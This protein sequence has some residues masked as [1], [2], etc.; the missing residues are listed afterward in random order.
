MRRPV[1]LLALLL[2][3]AALAEPKSCRFAQE[4]YNTLACTETDLEITV[5]LEAG[6]VSTPTGDL[7][8]VGTYD[9]PV[10]KTAVLEGFAGY[11][12]LTMGQLTWILS[13]HIAAGPAVATYYGECG[14][15]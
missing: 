9:G 8:I 3:A 7:E 1:F 10:A 5:D 13:V 4:C 12:L 6:Q 11:Q 14:A 2:P 15:D